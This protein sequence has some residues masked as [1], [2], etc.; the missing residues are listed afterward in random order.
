MAT[1][2]DPSGYTTVS[3][4]IEATPV[5]G[6][7]DKLPDLTDVCEGTSV[8]ASLT[9][10]SGGSGIDVL[11]YSTNGG[12]TWVAYTSG[13]SISTTG[14]TSVQIRTRRNASYCTPLDYTTVSWNVLTPTVTAP[15]N[16][17]VVYGCIPDAMSV[18]ATGL[19]T[20]TYQWFKT[21][22]ALDNVNGIAIPGETQPTY[23]PAYTN[24]GSYY[25]YVVVTDECTSVASAVATL[26]VTAAPANPAGNLYYTGPIFAFTANPSSSTASVMLSAVI[27]NPLPC[28]GGDIRTAFITFTL[29][30]KPIPSAQNLP[31]SFVDPDKPYLGGTA[32]ALV[33]LNVA[34][35]SQI[36]EIGVV[37][38]GNYTASPAVAPG[39][40]TVMQPSAGGTIGGGVDLCG[41]NVV[42]LIKGEDAYVHFEVKYS[43]TGKNIRNPKGRVEMTVWSYY[44]QFGIL[45]NELKTYI[46][47]SNA[48]SSLG[49][50]YPDA[51]F[52]AKANVSILNSDATLTPIEGNCTMI[53]EITDNDPGLLGI[54]IYRS[55]SKGGIWFSNNWHETENKTV[56]IEVCDGDLQVAGASNMQQLMSASIGDGLAQSGMRVYP[57]PFSS[58]V[59]FEFT[60]AT[61]AE[62]RLEIFDIRGAKL[63]TLFNNSVEAG[64]MYRI[65]YVPT[66][67][68]SGMLMYRLTIGGEVTHGKI[69]YQ[70]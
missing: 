21:T 3:W 45:T 57:N 5:N 44:D 37:I 33:Q 61:M 34:G 4:T 25:Y 26:T 62:A 50:N 56:P 13:T 40:I 46:I 7:L 51:L 66:N 22:T 36:F 52:T 19:G 10:G 38:S 68:P 65:D 18:T 58:K 69:L 54:T 20:L 32:A 47:R 16:I 9:P 70:R 8:S 55:K 53:L 41:G 17:T 2:C 27:K 48:I 15:G 12:T 60:P 24:V 64:Q 14:L 31:V 29:D 30:G 67:V 49:I 63:A 28:D 43:E 1:Y 39:Y 42:G 6:T 23:V 59:F 35:S 11:E